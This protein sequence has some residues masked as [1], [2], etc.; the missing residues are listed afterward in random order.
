MLLL[1]GTTDTGK[2]VYKKKK[3]N[4]MRKKSNSRRKTVDGFIMF[5][6][7]M[8]YM[9][10]KKTNKASVLLVYRITSVGNAK[11]TIHRFRAV[12]HPLILVH[13]FIAALQQLFF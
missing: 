4:A 6:S 1:E 3:I 9:K 5:S 12:H 10:K 2:S 11:F 8:W 7:L 13:D